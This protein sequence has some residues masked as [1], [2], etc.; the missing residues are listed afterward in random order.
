MIVG[1]YYCKYILYSRACVRMFVYVL[2][3]V[4][5]RRERERE[6]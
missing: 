4:S 5:R 3:Y 6:R 2:V 1:M